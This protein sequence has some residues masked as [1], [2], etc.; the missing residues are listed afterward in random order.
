MTGSDQEQ[1]RQKIDYLFQERRKIEDA[2]GGG[3]DPAFRNTYDL[4]ADEIRKL[5]AQ[6]FAV[7]Y[8]DFSARITHVTE[9]GRS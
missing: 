9:L 6:L 2:S 8:Q 5:H 1:Y 7:K 3:V 4:I